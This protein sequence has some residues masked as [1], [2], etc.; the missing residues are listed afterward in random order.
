M[1]DR[2]DRASRHERDDLRSKLGH[3]GVLITDDDGGHFVVTDNRLSTPCARSVPVAQRLLEAAL[4]G[5]FGL[6]PLET[7]GITAGQQWAFESA[8]RYRATLVNKGAMRT[9]NVA[10]LPYSYIRNRKLD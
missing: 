7:Y 5:S 9:R 1:C 8:T 2:F 6:A 3:G 4:S 10:T